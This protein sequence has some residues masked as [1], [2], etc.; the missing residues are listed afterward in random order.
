MLH[1]DN[2]TFLW[3]RF[4]GQRLLPS[5]T[6]A[7]NS[8][9]TSVYWQSPGID[10]L[11]TWRTSVYSDIGLLLHSSP[12]THAHVIMCS[13]QTYTCTRSLTDTQPV[14]FFVPL[15][16][17]LPPFGLVNFKNINSSWM[18]N[19]TIFLSRVANWASHC[20]RHPVQNVAC[21]IPL[22]CRCKLLQIYSNASSSAWSCRT[23]RNKDVNFLLSEAA[24]TY[25][26][27]LRGFYLGSELF[28]AKLS[29]FFHSF[30]CSCIYIYI[31]FY[32]HIVCILPIY[33]TVKK[34]HTLTLI[35]LVEKLNFG[36]SLGENNCSIYTFKLPG[37]QEFHTC[38][39]FQYHTWN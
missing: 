25:A 23:W 8:F 18:N 39:F 36:H 35:F 13:T 28:R 20:A 30:I 7:V 27:K 12:R 9:V 22:P 29:L 21:P 14:F 32:R 1:F 38:R 19:D 16:S 6:P 2:V 33:Y 11:V 3:T 17:Y 4:R 24:L 37:K 5:Y 31:F 26:W 34:A 15:Y 10:S